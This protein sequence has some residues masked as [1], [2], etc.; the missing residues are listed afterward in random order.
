MD[1]FL[2]DS[3][4]EA[5]TIKWITHKLQEQLQDEIV[6]TEIV[7]NQMLLLFEQ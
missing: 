6:I 5:F 4:D 1:S 3:P 2:K 7:A